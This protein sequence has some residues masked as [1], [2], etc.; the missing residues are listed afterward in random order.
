[1]ITQPYAAKVEKYMRYRWDY[2]DQAVRSIWDAMGDVV[3]ACIA[4]IGSG[5]GIVA[6]HFV[7]HARLVF[8]IEPD[9]GML[10]CACRSLAHYSS[11]RSIDACAEA[12]TLPD[13]CVDMIV[14]GQ[15]IHWFDPER[16]RREFLRILKPQGWLAILWNHG[17]DRLLGAELQAILTEQNGWNACANTNQSANRPLSFYYG[18]DD[19]LRLS[20]PLSQKETWDEFIGALCSDSHAPDEDHPLYAS[21]V[22]AARKVFDKLNTGGLVHVNYATELA[23]G[24]IYSPE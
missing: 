14:V 1:M 3:A 24:R 9:P 20:F 23:L 19:Y 11:F 15:A 6:R 12:T 10:A 17:T 8:A 22:S 2:A 18:R 21:F 7:D 4:D 5:T 16:A 13:R